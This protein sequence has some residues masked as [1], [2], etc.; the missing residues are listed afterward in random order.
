MS[1]SLLI[2]GATGKQG[3]AAIRSLVSRNA[4]FRLLAVTRDK[5]SRSAQ[6]LASLSPK[7]TLLQGDLNDTDAIFAHARDLSNSTPWG[8]FSVQAPKMGGKG[9]ADEQAQGISLID[10]AL[11]AGVKHFVYSSVDRHGDKSI[12]NPTDIPHFIS[13]HNIEH[14]LINSTKSNDAMSWTILRPVAFMENL[15]GGFVGKLFAT[16][17]KARLSQKPLQLIATED[18]GGAAAEAFL[19]PEEHKGKAISLAGDEVTFP[20]LSE[21]FREK[22]GADIPLTW[23]ILAKLLL[24]SSKEMRTMFSFFEKEGYAADIEALRRQYPRLKDVRTWL[25]TSPY[26]KK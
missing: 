13:K 6:K 4:D 11:K 22:T 21:I 10:S 23:G 5:T 3:G 26:M 9:A 14:H 16:G 18:I 17:I 2:T 24:A 12:N 15:D 7:V 20:Q 19:H 8:V 25:E 1:R